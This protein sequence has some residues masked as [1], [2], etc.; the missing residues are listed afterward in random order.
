MRN[1]L[2]RGL[3]KYAN[4]KFF[5]TF[6]YTKTHEY[7]KITKDNSIAQ[8]GI[9]KYAADNIGEIVFVEM[10][11]ADD[12]LNKNEVFTVLESTKSANDI[13]MPVDG[14]IEEVNLELSVNLKTNL[15]NEDPLGKGWLVKIKYDKEDIVKLMD[16]KEYN[17][18]LENLK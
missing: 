4:T 9:S 7:I 2:L 16:E 13:Y 17:S 6:K 11:N 14:K 18:Y 1:S 8:V 15:I 10:S 3:N 5:S 12:I